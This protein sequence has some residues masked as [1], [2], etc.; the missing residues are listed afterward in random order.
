MLRHKLLIVSLFVVLAVTSVCS[1]EDGQPIA[2]RHWP[3]G[4]FTIETMWNLHVGSGLNAKSKEMLPRAVDYEVESL[5]EAGQVRIW[6]MPNKAEVEFSKDQDNDV[7]VSEAGSNDVDISK[8]VESGGFNANADGVWV[9]SV[10]GVAPADMDEVKKSFR[11]GLPAILE[12]FGGIENFHIC[13]IA[14]DETFDADFVKELAALGKPEIMIVNSK[15]DS[16]GDVTVQKVEHNTIA[17]SASGKRKE[18][19]RFVS[20]GT[21]PYKMS[22]DLKDLFAK[23]EASQKASREMFSKLSVEQ[24]NFKPNNG[25]HTPR[26]NPE[27][28]M[29]MELLFFSQIY[30]AVDPSVPVLDLRPNQMPEDYEFAHSDW[31]GEEEAR[32]M[33]RVEEFT[34]RFAYL[35][36]GMDLNK[37]AKGSRF[38]SPRK[39]LAQMER[40]YKEHSANVV[41]KMELEG[42]PKK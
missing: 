2:I 33:K 24:M 18:E 11:E 37:R 41:K 1:A 42:W 22:D 27:H 9:L 13:I 21:T 35:L 40:H 34:R 8:P 10:N 32:Q 20:L 28:M 38:W 39:L 31:T 12:E 6:R 36:D 15:F 29:A 26:W 16:I 25:S 3:G 14:T 5:G 23:K 19:T 17:I 4:G 7:E 30:H